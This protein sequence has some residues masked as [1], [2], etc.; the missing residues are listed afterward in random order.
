MDPYKSP[1]SETPGGGGEVSHRAGRPCSKCGSANTVTNML[2]RPKPSLLFV[3]LFG[4]LFLL[5]RCA[6]AIRT[7]ICQDCGA[8]SRYKSVGSWIALVALILF[9]ALIVMDATSSVEPG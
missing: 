1:E 3:F 8:P 9:V 4:W 7:D 6:F 2:L 5:M